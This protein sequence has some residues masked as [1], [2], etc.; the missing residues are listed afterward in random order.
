RISIRIGRRLRGPSPAERRRLAVQARIDLVRWRAA[1]LAGEPQR[2]LL[3]VHEHARQRVETAAGSRSINAYLDPI[4]EQLAGGPLDPIRLDI[5]AQAG[6]EAD[7][8]RIGGEGDARLL[9]VEALVPT[10]TSDIRGG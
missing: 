9:T 3:V 2:R 1:S 8:I 6:R 5:R 7:W 10:G 4:V